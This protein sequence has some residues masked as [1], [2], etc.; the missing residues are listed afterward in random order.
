MQQEI[1]RKCERGDSEANARDS[2]YI[3]RLRLLD[4]KMKPLLNRG[5]E[6]CATSLNYHCVYLPW[7]CPVDLRTS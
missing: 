5:M 1:S 4:R 2:V 6:V 7:D 3:L